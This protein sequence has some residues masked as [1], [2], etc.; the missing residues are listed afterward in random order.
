MIDALVVG[1]PSNIVDRRLCNQRDLA[2]FER[3]TGIKKTRH[4]ESDNTIA[5]VLR[6]IKKCGLDF[7]GVDG[8]IVVTQS[9]DRLS[10]CMAVEVHRALDLPSSAPV[11]DVNHA[12]DGFIMGLYLARWFSQKTLLVCVDRLR[13]APSQIESLIFSDAVSLSIVSFGDNSFD[14][15]TQPNIADLYCGL[16]GDMEMN[17]PAVFD[18]ATTKVPPMIKNFKQKLGW[19]IDFLV[20]HQANLTMNKIIELRSGFKDKCLYS[21][22]EYGNQSMN[23]IPTALAMNENKILGKNLLLC[24]FG[25]GYTAALAYLPHW[26]DFPISR[27]V[28]I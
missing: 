24:G 4:Y 1:V 6:T 17:G 2:E 26:S 9:P 22:E 5:M 13:Y 23:S 10:P 3:V 20:P 16:H 19:P 12:C 14:F 27:I 7:K 21:I 28:E 8:V 18:F 15:Y 11:I 25:A